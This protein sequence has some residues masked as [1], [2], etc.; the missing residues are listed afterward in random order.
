MGKAS[1]GSGRCSCTRVGACDATGRPDPGNQ[2]PPCG[3]EKPWRSEKGFRLHTTTSQRRQHRRDGARTCCGQEQAPNK[4]PR[5]PHY[6]WCPIA[7]QQ[8]VVQVSGRT[9]HACASLHRNFWLHN[10]KMLVPSP[11]LLTRSFEPMTRTTTI[12]SL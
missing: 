10:A 8:L 12:M 6:A 5:R 11:C 7:L 3:I 9:E 4:Q 2:V 1:Y